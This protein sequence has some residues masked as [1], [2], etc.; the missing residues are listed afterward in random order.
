M[1]F[2]MGS[3]LAATLLLRPHNLASDRPNW[4]TARAMIRSAIF[5]SGI[6]PLNI[7]ELQDDKVARAKREDVGP[8]SRWSY[9]EIPTVHV[10]SCN[11]S[12]IPGESRALADMCVEDKRV[13]LLHSAGHAIPS[14]GLELESAA[15]AIR[16]LLQGTAG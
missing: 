5:L 8:H 4:A 14:E 10:W 16:R 2:S 12:E 1:G 6:R 9:I 3:S 13:E 7:M 15:A 11:D